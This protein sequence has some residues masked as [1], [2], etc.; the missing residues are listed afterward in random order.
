LPSLDHHEELVE[1]PGVAHP[2]S[3]SAKRPCILS[4]EGPTPLSDRLVGDGD[5]S[6]GEQIFGISK[7]Q[8]EAMVEPHRVT[9]NLGWE[10]VSVVIGGVGQLCQLPAQLNNASR[11]AKSL[12]EA[13]TIHSSHLRS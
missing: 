9:D 12:R 13:A 4:A 3:S 2:P 10:S 7:A 5:A 6:L 8:A 1:I 11:R